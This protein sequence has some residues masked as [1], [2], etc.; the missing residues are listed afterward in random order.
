MTVANLTIRETIA[1]PGLAV[2]VRRLR[3]SRIL[4]HLDHLPGCQ[5]A[6]PR[7]PS[8]CSTVLSLNRYRFANNAESRARAA[9]ARTAQVP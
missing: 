9:L 5:R 1:A 6:H 7:A 4:A 8:I 3:R 2:Q